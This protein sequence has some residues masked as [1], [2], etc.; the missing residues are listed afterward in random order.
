LH[1]ATGSSE[2]DTHE[3]RLIPDTPLGGPSGGAVGGTPARK[4]A[5]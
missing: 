3:D 1:E 4:R 5:K 2:F